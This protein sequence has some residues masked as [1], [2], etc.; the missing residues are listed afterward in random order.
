MSYYNSGINFT[1]PIWRA[2]N[3]ERDREGRERGRVRAPLELFLWRIIVILGNRRF[4]RS[5]SLLLAAAVRVD[6]VNVTP[7]WY[8]HLKEAAASQWLWDCET[9][10]VAFPSLPPSPFYLFIN[11]KYSSDVLDGFTAGI[12]FF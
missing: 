2:R 6:N 11:K 12:R 3:L 7:P 9:F 8:A 1:F 10:L 4:E 5:L